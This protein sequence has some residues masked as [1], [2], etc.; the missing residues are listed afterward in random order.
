MFMCLCLCLCVYIM[1]QVI[2]NVKTVRQM[3]VLSKGEKY[4]AVPAHTVHS[5]STQCQYTLYTTDAGSTGCRGQ[6]V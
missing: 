1:E 3:E 6:A 2:G 5:A 4:L